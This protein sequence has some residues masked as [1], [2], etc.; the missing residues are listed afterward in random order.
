MKPSLSS[1]L[2]QSLTLIVMTALAMLAT[3]ALGLLA[4]H[5]AG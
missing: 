2:R 4:A 5:I 1:E 3:I